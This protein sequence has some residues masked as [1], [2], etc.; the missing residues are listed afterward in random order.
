MEDGQ[1]GEGYIVLQETLPA[2][3]LA[4]RAQQLGRSGL[5]KAEACCGERQSSGRSTERRGAA[6]VTRSSSLIRDQLAKLLDQTQAGPAASV[7]QNALCVRE[8]CISF[9][10]QFRS[11]K[12]GQ[13]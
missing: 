12:G 1:V 4:A 13:R 6:Q 9:H 7:D 2:A 11:A 8:Q 3:G 5:A 10:S